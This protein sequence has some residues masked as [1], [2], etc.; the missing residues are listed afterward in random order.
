M[1][2]ARQSWVVWVVLVSAGCATTVTPVADPGAAGAPSTPAAGSGSAACVGPGRYE[3]DGK[4]AEPYRPC[5]EGL[6]EDLYQLAGWTG[7]LGTTPSCWSPP[8]RV[9]ACVRGS[10]GDG[11]CEEGESAPCGCV[12]DCPSA[13]WETPE[14][15]AQAGGED[16]LI[17]VPASCSKADLVAQLQINP[18]AKDCG[19]LALDASADAQASAIACALER[20]GNQQAFQVFWRTQGTDSVDHHG[21]VGRREQNGALVVYAVYVDSNVFSVD[22]TGASASWSPCFLPPGSSCKG[23]LA[24]CLGC[25]P[26]SSHE[27]CACLPAG[28]R[29][30]A[31]DGASVEVR[32]EAR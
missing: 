9:Y 11:V 28:H 7:D 10:C 24:Q 21:L 18:D 8:L 19:D 31:P 5:C 20:Y 30:G 15:V 1:T 6:H 23:T 27:V 17:D 14:N 3:H 29:P 13:A 12:K 2:L 22:I 32:C 4:D 26:Y 25:E 16:S